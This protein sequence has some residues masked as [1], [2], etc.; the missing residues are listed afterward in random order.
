EE[1][2]VGSGKGVIHKVNAGQALVAQFGTEIGA[3][4]A[5]DA[6]GDGCWLGWPER[7]DGLDMTVIRER[8]V[9]GSEVLHGVAL[10]I[11]HGDRQ[12]NG[13]TGGCGGSGGGGLR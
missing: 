13:D 9:G 7:G 10:F 11:D 8:D 12:R 4:L 5:E 6:K 1:L 2:V 3:G